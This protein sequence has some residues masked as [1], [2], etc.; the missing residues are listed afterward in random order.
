M[1]KKAACISSSAHGGYL[2]A[3]RREGRGLRWRA[4]FPQLLA[5]AQHDC[6]KSDDYDL[7]NLEEEEELK[8]ALKF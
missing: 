6:K 8:E 4:A 1:P 2:A 5:A 3:P 7:A